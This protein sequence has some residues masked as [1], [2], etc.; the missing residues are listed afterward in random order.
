M[1]GCINCS[2]PR[3]G[4]RRG[5][6]TTC[7]KVLE[8]WVVSGKHTWEELEEKG[9]VLPLNVRAKRRYIEDFFDLCKNR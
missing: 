6:C 9:L 4:G 5:V 3:A 8:R 1:I 2:N 7:V